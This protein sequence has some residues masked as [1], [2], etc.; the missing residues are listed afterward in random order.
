[1]K[2]ERP[3]VAGGAS[4]TTILLVAA[5]CMACSSTSEALSE[6]VDTARLAAST[7]ND[8]SGAWVG[9]WAASPQSGGES[10][11]Q[12]T[13]RQIVHTSIA[14]RAAR[15]QFSNAFGTQPLHLSD[16]HIAQRTSGSSVSS[17][18][19]RAVT[20]AGQTDVT[21]AAGGV[22][23]S[24]LVD[25]SVAALSDV[26]I[27]VYFP[28]STGP[29]TYHQQGTQTNYVAAG[30]LSA[31][32]SL[33]GAETLGSYFFLVNLDVQASSSTGSL[34]ALGASITDGYA[35]A[36]DANHRWPNYL[37]IRLSNAGLAAG[38]LNQGINGNRLLVDGSG[39][40]ALN[41]FGRDVLSQPGVAWV[42]FSDDPINDLG[43]TA[44]AP[45]ADQ[46]VAGAMHLIASAHQSGIKFLC[47]TLT[48]FE[49]ASYW[50]QAGETGREGFNAFVRGPHS[51][52][53]GL[54]DQDLAT[55]DPANPTR[56]LPA[57]D[58]G[59]HLHPNDA[60]RQA[61]ANAVDLSLLSTTSVSLS[62]DASSDVASDVE[63]AAPV[64]DAS[65]DTANEA[66][67]DTASAADGNTHDDDVL[68]A[69]GA[70]SN[71]GDDDAMQGH[72]EAS[73]RVADEGG[74]ATSTEGASQRVGCSAAPASP[75]DAPWS[76]VFIVLAIAAIRADT[77]T[78]PPVIPRCEK[79]LP[80]SSRWRRS[81]FPRRS[82]RSKTR[83]RSAGANARGDAGRD[84]RASS[85]SAPVTIAPTSHR[86][87]GAPA[88]GRHFPSL[89]AGALPT[90]RRIDRGDVDLL[91]RHDSPSRHSRQSRS[92]SGPFLPDCRW[93]FG[94]VE[95]P[96][97]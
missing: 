11:N 16:V 55:H 63:P 56:F 39:Q 22:S 38:V 69:R 23:A 71:P 95:Y 37:A 44:P 73:A 52:C 2:R 30:D 80:P 88:W 83:P 74:A 90:A 8:A 87:R 19:D 7:P 57:F 76:V 36:Q 45:S 26:A 53:D 5:A 33:S 65:S 84:R 82:T 28:Q 12:Q 14:G 32:A 86:F 89:P 31:N 68:G 59:D 72:D 9:T 3:C 94:R 81:H 35:S 67:S 93:R 91:H 18:T 77:R 15:V 96:T 78:Q 42:I 58:S 4:I 85:V 49:G 66:A 64:E 34:V 60:G 46:L 27:S 41:R 6:R 17:E 29:A 70:S 54:V 79:I 20:F 61:I 21:V 40:S 92:S 43:S 50:T 51:G 75:R 25:F 10:F 62:G 48:P 24:D 47:S 97:R 1:M 13:L